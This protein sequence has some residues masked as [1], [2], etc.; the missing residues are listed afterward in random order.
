M[1]IEWKAERGDRFFVHLHMEGTDRRGLLGDVARTITDT[2]T[3]IQHADMRATH[4]GM[5][6]EFAVEVHD[7]NHLKRVMEAV[8]GVK[9]VLSV[10]R[11]ESF[12]ESD[13]FED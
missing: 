13:L 10:V 12:G 5:T 11:R 6:A 4:G 2:G 9:G 1:E 3:D 7:L 8:S